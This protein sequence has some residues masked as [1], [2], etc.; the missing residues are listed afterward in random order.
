MKKSILIMMVFFATIPVMNAQTASE[1]SK[2]AAAT[3][4]LSNFEMTQT[5]S[6]FDAKGNQ[7]VRQTTSKSLN[8]GDATKTLI[9]FNS[10]ADVAGTS[11]LVYDYDSKEDDMWIYLPAL[12]KSRRIVSTEKKQSF[13][14][15]EFTNSDM[16]KPNENEYNYK[17]LADKN[18][19]GTICYAIEMVPISKDI[20]KKYGFSK[21]VCYIDKV[22]YLTQKVEYFDATGK[23]TREMVLSKYEPVN[24]VSGKYFAHRIEMLNQVTGR[25]SVITVDAINTKAVIRDSDLSPVVLGAN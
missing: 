23:I 17:K 10:P 21:K 2:K 18:I 5:L 20:E 7:R 22:K 13:M 24:G 1:I 14:G 4:E 3:V 8:S 19:N 16:S 6:I 11:M 9:V 15:S 25:K 12:R